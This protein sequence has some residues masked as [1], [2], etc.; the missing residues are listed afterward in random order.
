MFAKINHIS[1]TFSQECLANQRQRL[2]DLFGL[3]PGNLP[4]QIPSLRCLHLLLC[5]YS[6]VS[7]LFLYKRLHS[8]KC[9]SVNIYLLI[10][11]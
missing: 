8:L 5:L 11:V 1:S 3:F 6:L 9:V 7:F 4:L 10:Q 2:G